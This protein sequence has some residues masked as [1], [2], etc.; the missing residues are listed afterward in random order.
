MIAGRTLAL[1]STSDALVV[2]SGGER[3]R[4]CRDIYCHDGH[5]LLYGSREHGSA[6]RWTCCSPRPFLSIAVLV[7][8]A[9]G[10]GPCL[11]SGVKAV[12]R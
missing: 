4:C 6:V 9:R 8:D 1:R 5:D 7:E 12:K 2:H 11:R 10:A 3:T